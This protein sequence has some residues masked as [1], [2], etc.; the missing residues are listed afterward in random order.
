MNFLLRS[1]L[2]SHEITYQELTQNLN[3]EKNE[4]M[5][6][7][8]TMNDLISIA[9]DKALESS[10]LAAE[11]DASEEISNLQHELDEKS[12]VISNLEKKLIELK[13]EIQEKDLDQE[14]FDEMEV[15]NFILQ[16]KLS[17]HEVTYQEQ[18]EALCQ[19]KNEKKVLQKTM[20]DL[21]TFTFDYSTEKEKSM[22]VAESESTKEILNLQQELEQKSSVISNLKTQLAH[23]KERVQEQ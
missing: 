20:D 18:K 21:V 4:K 11:S 8:Q 5:V 3:H 10:I 16:S 22:I 13:N 12:Q 1:K 17:S 9:T 15:K 19:E 2:A 7:Q 23:L 14:K 6:L